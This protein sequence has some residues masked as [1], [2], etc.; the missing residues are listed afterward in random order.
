MDYHLV[1]KSTQIRTEHLSHNISD[2]SSSSIGH[3]YRGG[4]GGGG[5]PGGELLGV[6]SSDARRASFESAW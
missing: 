5:G 4:G 2:G 3:E 1:E 6:R